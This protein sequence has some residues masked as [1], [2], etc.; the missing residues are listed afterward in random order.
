VV[1]PMPVII[2]SSRM[3]PSGVLCKS[4]TLAGLIRVLTWGQAGRAPRYGIEFDPP[5]IRE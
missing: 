5:P 1:R 4:L 2:F 3:K